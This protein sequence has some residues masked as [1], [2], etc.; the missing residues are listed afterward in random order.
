[1]T[2]LPLAVLQTPPP[3]RLVATPFKP[4]G[5]YRT[6]ERAGWTV[7]LPPDAAPGPYRYSLRRNNKDEIRAGELDLSSGS[8]TIETTERDPAML[9]LEI[10]PAT[11]RPATYGAAVDPRGLK[12][13]VPKP[14]DFDAFWKG[15]LAA[16]RAIPENPVLRP[17]TSYKPEV[18]YATLQMDH[19]SG[20]HVYGQIARPRSGGKHPAVLV[21]QW[22]SPPYPLQKPWVVEL[23]AQGWLALNIEPHDVISNGEPAY[24]Q[25]LPPYQKNYAATGRDDREKSAF[26]EMVLRDVRAVDYLSKLPDWDGKTLVVMGTSMGGQQSLYA[27]GLCPQVTHMIVNEPAGADMNAGL[28]GRQQGYPSFDVRESNTMEAA[29]YVDPINFAPRIR[30]TSLVAMGFTDDVAPPAGIWTAFNLIKGPKEAAPMVDSPHNNT[31]TPAQQRPYTQ[32]AAEWLD[33]LV[34]GRKVHPRR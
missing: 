8:A 14:K 1:M 27:A 25:S 29:R 33:A 9:F 4:S 6:G 7:T 15:R 10:R 31:A 18:E 12:P 19:V 3:V 26:V 17:G 34:H 23:A 11:G 22:A 20:T 13:V 5:L 2:L 16:L 24:Y 28:H 30:A 21:L 32:R